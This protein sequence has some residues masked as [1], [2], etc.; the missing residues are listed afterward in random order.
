MDAGWRAGV[1]ARPGLHSQRQTTLWS[2]TCHRNWTSGD[3]SPH[4]VQLIRHADP[5]RAISSGAC[6]VDSRLGLT[7]G[8]AI[9]GSAASSTSR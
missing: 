8:F 4:P 1:L 7:L 2:S 5:M 3:D 9:C 6:P